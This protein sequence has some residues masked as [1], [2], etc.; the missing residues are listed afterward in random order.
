MKHESYQKLIT[1]DDKDPPWM[2]DSIRKSL[3]AEK[4]TC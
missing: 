3:M 2:N 1:V 4:Y